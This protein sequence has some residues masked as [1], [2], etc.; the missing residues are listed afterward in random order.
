MVFNDSFFFVL[1]SNIISLP[2]LLSW[3]RRQLCGRGCNSY[4]FW[5]G[6]IFPLEGSTER[7]TE[8]NISTLN[9]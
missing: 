5:V 1:Q 2:L 8:M 9:S 6:F 3:Q 7:E 4:L